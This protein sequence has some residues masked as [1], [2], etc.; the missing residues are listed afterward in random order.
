LNG[1][2]GQQQPILHRGPQQPLS[3]MVV[4]SGSE[5]D[6][7]VGQ[8]ADDV[9]LGGWEH[10]AAGGGVVGPVTSHPIV[11]SPENSRVC[12]AAALDS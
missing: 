4:D 2:E 3:V 8:T 1:D 12:P 5:Q 7:D 6:T 11:L 9:R 10:C